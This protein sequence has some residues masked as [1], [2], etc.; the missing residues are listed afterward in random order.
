MPLKREVTVDHAGSPRLTYDPEA[1]A[2][3]VYL[4]RPGDRARTRVDEYGVI[5]D[6]DIEGNILGVEILQ[7]R[8][9][10][11]DIKKLPS[12]VVEVVQEFL[13]SGAIERGES[14]GFGRH[15]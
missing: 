4:N 2:I 9:R 13:D 1:D 3:Y 14:V 6:V 12:C 5:T 7:V 15:M 11:I 10:G 8:F